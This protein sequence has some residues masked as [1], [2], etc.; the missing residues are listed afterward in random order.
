LA[1]LR[2]F[3]QTNT[4]FFKKKYKTHN[5]RYLFFQNICTLFVFPTLDSAKIQKIGLFFSAL[6]ATK[7]HRVSNASTTRRK[8]IGNTSETHRQRVGNAKK[9]KNDT[10]RNVKTASLE[11]TVF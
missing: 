5:Y 2:I 8:R 1:I 3:F 4:H 11:K 7:R 10:A 9:G 6:A